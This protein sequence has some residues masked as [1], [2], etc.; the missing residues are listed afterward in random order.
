MVLGTYHMDEPGLDA[1]TL[2]VDDVLVPRRQAE[3]EELTDSLA[4][5]NPDRVAVERPY[6]RADAVNALYDEYRAGERAYDREEEID[7]PHPFRNEPDTEC[8]SEVV[9]I[10]F[11]L[12]EK[13]DH[14]RVSPI[15][16]PTKLGNEEVEALRERGFE[17]ETKVSASLPDPEERVREWGRRLADSSIVEFHRWLNREEQVSANNE[18]MF[19]EYLRLGEGDN[20]GGPRLLATWYERNL[21]M[22]HALWRAI[23]PDDRRV[24]VLVG[25]GHVPVLRH[26]LEETPTFRPVGPRS[27]L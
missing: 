1:A 11:R 27:H 7:P 18:A 2:D 15:D 14:E 19:D 16:S 22:V 24:L 12:A 9:Q 5:W 4:R 23:E 17:P 3:L 20:F 26:L 25:N 13:L 21:R 8:R 6:D 10:G